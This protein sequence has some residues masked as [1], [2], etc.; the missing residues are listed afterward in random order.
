MNAAE[1]IASGLLEAYVLGQVSPDEARLVQASRAS[2]PVVA[3]ELDAIEQALQEW[4]MRNA[5]PPPAASKPA[6]FN[7][8]EELNSMVQ[9]STPV[10]SFTQA[11]PMSEKRSEASSGKWLAA[12]SI[13]ALVVSA[14]FNWMQYRQ[15]NEARTEVARLENDKAVLAEDMNVQRASFEQSQNQLAVVM[16]PQRQTILLNGVG[17]AVGEKARIYWDPKASAVHIDPMTLAD[18]PEGKQYQLWALVDG[19][20][21]DA[22]VIGKGEA[23]HGLQ[24]MKDVPQAQ[25]FAVTIEKEG[26]SP[27]PTLEAMVLMGQV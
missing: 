21:I 15:L 11:S 3:A 18:L 22:G 1:L 4:A 17:N 8:V 10:I 13:A 6:I 16:D 25:A 20:P 2:D 27:T 12:A 5:V 7:R 9:S 23:S 19:K 24:R 26:G 14:A